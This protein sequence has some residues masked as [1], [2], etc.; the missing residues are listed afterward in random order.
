MGD[1]VHRHPPSNGLGSNT[2]VQD[3]YNLA[4][5]LAMV[6]RGEAGPALLDSYTAERAPVGR[7][8]VERANLSRDQFGPV[9]DTLGVGADGDEQTIA[10]GLAALRAATPEGAKRRRQLEDAI[11]LKNYEFNAHGVEMNQRYVS[12]AVVAD[13]PRR[14]LG[15]GP[16]AGGPSHHPP[17]CQAPTRGSSTATAGGSPPWTSSAR[18]SSPC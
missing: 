16:G 13:G 2:S 5:K 7:Q 6:I 10:Q 1:A 9:F 3:A 18:A 11:R 4:W 17:G 8:I 14:G 15:R 12:D